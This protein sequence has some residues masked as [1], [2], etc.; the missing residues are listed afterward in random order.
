[1]DLDSRASCSC[2]RRRCV[3]VFCFLLF[4]LPPELARGHEPRSEARAQP[5][6]LSTP[7][8]AEGWSF[9]R[10]FSPVQNALGSRRRMVQF[11]TIGMCIGLFILMRK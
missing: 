1:M 3:W 11:A 7:L 10:L 2:S 5:T 4:L 8:L 9:R 6:V